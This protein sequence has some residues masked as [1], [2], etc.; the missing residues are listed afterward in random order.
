M[1]FDALRSNKNAQI[2]LGLFFGI[3]FGFLLQKS[4]VTEYGVIL[5]QLLL[6]D[7]TVVK[8]MLSA[9][10]VGMIGVYAMKAAGLVNLHY[11]VGSIGATIIGGLIF[12]AGFAILGYCPGTVAGAVGS[13]AVD[14]LIGMI[15]IVIGAGVFARLYPR[16]NRTI[17]NRGVFP[18]ETIPELIGV[19]PMIVVAG[20]AVLIVG[21]LYLLNFAGL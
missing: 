8:V 9:I 10:I 15:G 21:V 11:K 18:A 7:F 3:I 4:G 6:T 5:G 1:T 2:V 19:R 12:G 16:L 14:A 20:V 13:G 17:L